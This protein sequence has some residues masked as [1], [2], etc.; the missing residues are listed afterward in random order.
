ML[1]YFI[2]IFCVCVDYY[3]QDKISKK[4]ENV[5][6]K[7]HKTFCTNT[8]FAMIVFDVISL[9]NPKFSSIK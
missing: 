6:S 7:H 5:L 3:F 4:G 9:A 1:D 8:E 2:I